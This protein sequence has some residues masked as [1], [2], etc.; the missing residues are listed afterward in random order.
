MN[1]ATLRVSGAD[2]SLE[3]LK[4]ML[5]LDCDV[6]WRKGDRRRD[7]SIY[8]S[9]GFNAGVADTDNSRK[10]VT[11]VRA[12]LNKCKEKSVVF[13]RL[14]LEAELDIGF[15]VGSSD[16]YVASVLFAPADL[17]LLA[18]CGIELRVTAY[19]TSDE[20]NAEDEKQ[21]NDED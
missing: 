17:L 4:N 1:V 18:E 9:S 21:K 19:P 12:F 5:Q 2:R 16:Q 20:A 11:H 15:T 13:S 7:G 14:N 3:Q 10:L 8:A 6:E